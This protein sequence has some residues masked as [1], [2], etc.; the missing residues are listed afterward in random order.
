MSFDRLGIPVTYNS[1][2]TVTWAS[3]MMKPGMTVRENL[4]Q[5]VQIVASRNK[6]SFIQYINSVIP[7]DMTQFKDLK[8][9]QT[10]L[11][12]KD[13][14]AIWVMKY[15]GIG[16]LYIAWVAENKWKLDPSWTF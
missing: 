11:T 4:K 8:D 10:R 6:D 13:P 5:T 3:S 16:L 14:A 12:N 7:S 9:W 15:M 2:G 1:D